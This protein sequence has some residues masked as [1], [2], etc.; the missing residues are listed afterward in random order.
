MNTQSMIRSANYLKSKRDQRL[1]N[2]QF[3]T[4]IGLFLTVGLVLIVVTYFLG[5]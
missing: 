5:G 1:R 4:G 3:W 2:R